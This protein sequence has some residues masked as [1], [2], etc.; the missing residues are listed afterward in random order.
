MS[1][2]VATGMKPVVLLLQ[3]HMRHLIQ[4]LTQSNRAILNFLFEIVQYSHTP[5][6]KEA[7][8]LVLPIESTFVPH[9]CFLQ[10]SLNK[11]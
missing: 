3:F 9:K 6:Q 8:A 1:T 5:S 11:F 4:R 10:A 2:T 7:R